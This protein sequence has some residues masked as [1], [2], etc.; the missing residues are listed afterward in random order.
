MPNCQM[1]YFMDGAN[2]NNFPPIIIGVSL[3][4][5]YKYKTCT[6]IK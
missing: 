5:L 4:N 1:T 2:Q 6:N 3:S